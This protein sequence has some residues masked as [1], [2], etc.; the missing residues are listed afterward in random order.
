MEDGTWYS[1]NV[2]VGLKDGVYESSSPFRHAKE[3]YDIL[4]SRMIDRFI[5]F[6]YMDGGPDHRLTYISVQLSLIA[7]FLHFNLDI[8]VAARTAPSHSWANP[9]ERIM[10]IINLG[11]Q[12]VGVMRKKIGDDCEQC[13]LKCHSLKELRNKCTQ[14]K[15]DVAE[16]LS[17]PKELLNSIIRRLQLH[18][19][20]F[21][22]FPSAS[23]SE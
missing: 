6:L 2:F 18:E 23:D 15:D 20:Y 8:L 13:V 4:S 3:L 5:L 9:V 10:S 12:C 1:G 16:S 7:L 22:T 14:F 11:F 21:N 19:R 17:Q